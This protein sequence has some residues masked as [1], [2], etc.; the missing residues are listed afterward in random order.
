MNRSSIIQILA[1]VRLG[2]T[3]RLGLL[4]A[5]C[6]DQEVGEAL[7]RLDGTE[8]LALLDFLD[9]PKR[10][11]ALL[12]LDYADWL[13]LIDNAGPVRIQSLIAPAIAPQSA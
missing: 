9:E 10:S 13:R 3:D 8:Q 4:L 7:A 2:R 11:A 12:S 6:S 5:D 1:L